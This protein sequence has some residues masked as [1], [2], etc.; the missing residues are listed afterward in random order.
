MIVD[1]PDF[2]SLVGERIVGNCEVNGIM[3]PMPLDSGSQVSTVN[4]EFIK[5]HLKATL[6]DVSSWLSVKAAN[7]LEFPYLGYFICVVNI[8]RQGLDEVGILVEATTKKD[9]YQGKVAGLI[10][11]NILDKIPVWRDWVQ[12]KLQTTS[13][14]GK[15]RVAS[16]IVVRPYSTC[17]VPVK[18]NKH[19]FNSTCGIIEGDDQLPGNIQILPTLD[20]MGQN[21]VELREFN[22]TV[23]SIHLKRHFVLRTLSPVTEI[24]HQTQAT[25]SLQVTAYKCTRASIPELQQTFQLRSLC[26]SQWIGSHVIPRSRFWSPSHRVCQQRF[27]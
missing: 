9:W 16:N 17:T 18:V 11:T 22:L 24:Q 2:A 15:V 21:Q 19:L 5:C 26:I 4:E 7:E 13:L 14:T 27:T 8:F 12:G 6:K 20:L 3:V 23:A 1:I 10:G 25:P